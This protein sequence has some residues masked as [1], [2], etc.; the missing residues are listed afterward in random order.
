MSYRIAF[1]NVK[2]PQENRAYWIDTSIDRQLLASHEHPKV[3]APYVASDYYRPPVSTALPFPGA[4]RFSST[5][6]SSFSSAPYSTASNFSSSRLTLPSSLAN[7]DTTSGPSRTLYSPAMEPQ[8]AVW[9]FHGRAKKNDLPHF[10]PTASLPAPTQSSQGERR[11]RSRESF[12][13][14]QQLAPQ[15]HC[16]WPS[17]LV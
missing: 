7:R 6:S 8:P 3:R 4:E 5:P 13:L 11:S 14:T 1:F 12:L 2:G 9:Q 16:K 17:L 15:H 10:G